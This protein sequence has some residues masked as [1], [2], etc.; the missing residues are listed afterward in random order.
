MTR[1]ILLRAFKGAGVAL[2]VGAVVSAILALLGRDVEIAPV[3]LMTVGIGIAE[4]V[5]GWRAGRPAAES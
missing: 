5:R 3:I 2:L 1:L 4:G